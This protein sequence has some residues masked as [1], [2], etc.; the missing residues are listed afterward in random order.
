M[1]GHEE[2]Y[3][4]IQC[5]YYVEEKIRY[6][7]HLVYSALFAK[8]IDSPEVGQAIKGTGL[9]LLY[10]MCFLLRAKLKPVPLGVAS[11][12]ISQ[13]CDDLS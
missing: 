12:S 7:L 11:L 6:I 9:K 5:E 1:F 13:K 10:N 2:R 8:P 4:V 3:L